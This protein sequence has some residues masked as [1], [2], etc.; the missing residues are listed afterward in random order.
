V[1][2]ANSEYLTWEIAATRQTRG[3]WSFGASFAHTWNADHA[4]GYS[5][6]SVR[7]NSYPL[8]PNDLINTGDGGRHEFRTW[9]AKA[10][11]TFEGPWRLGVTPVLRHQSGQ[12]FGRTQVTSRTQLSSGTITILMEPVGTRRMDNITILDVRID[13]TMRVKGGRVRAFVDVFNLLNANPAQNVVWTS[14]ESF[15]RPVTIVPPR[16]ARAGLSFDW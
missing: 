15:L 4:S 9:T 10:Y 14:G 1:P 2:G 13:R 12:P 7:S 5:G 11:G 8:T 3:R 6:Q 16:I